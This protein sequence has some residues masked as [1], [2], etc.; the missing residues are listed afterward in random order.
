MWVVVFAL[1]P[2]YPHTH[3]KILTQK[4]TQT[5]TPKADRKHQI[6]EGN[7]TRQATEQKVR[8]YGTLKGKMSLKLYFLFVML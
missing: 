3:I 8:G 2:H 6:F 7:L 1:T 5:Q 4:H